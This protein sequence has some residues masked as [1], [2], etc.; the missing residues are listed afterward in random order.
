MPT[1]FREILRANRESEYGRKYNF[2]N[3][4]GVA[5]YKGLV[6]TCV[7]Y[8]LFKNGCIYFYHFIKVLRKRIQ[9]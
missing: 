4:N 2:E 3:L 9:Y 1:Y 8:M 7:H 6:V 5:D